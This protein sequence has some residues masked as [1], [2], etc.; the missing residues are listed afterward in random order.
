[1]CCIAAR[2][3]NRLDRQS[4]RFAC[5][6]LVAL[7]QCRSCEAHVESARVAI[8]SKKAESRPKRIEEGSATPKIRR[9]L[10]RRGRREPETV[11][12]FDN[13]SHGQLC[14]GRYPAVSA[15]CG[16]GN[17]TRLSGEIAS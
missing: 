1:M 13:R 6:S 4:T 10:R 8:G 2:V 16:L 7:L 17:G 11:A 3:D 15:A 5:R 12:K 14:A 9:R